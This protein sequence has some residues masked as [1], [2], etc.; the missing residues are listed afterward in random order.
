M[1]AIFNRTKG[2]RYIWLIV[3]ILTVISM[4]AV[5]S[6]TGSL[7]FKYQDGNTEYYLI[8]HLGIFAF[9][10]FLM[11]L[12]H[13]MNYKYYS[14][15][16]LFFWLASI[17]LLLYTLLFGVEINDAKRWLTIPLINM[18]FQTSDLAKLALIMY[19][20]RV[21]SKKQETIKDF[22]KGFLP[23]MLPPVITCALIAPSNLSTV[24]TAG[25]S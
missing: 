14:R 18:S 24:K 4:L 5:Y 6:S 12:A 16:A 8:K 21:L 17:P 22:R 10:L 20:A 9:G 23:V 25:A 2:D 1:E 3:I 15:I 13:L 11:Y 19:M 7:A